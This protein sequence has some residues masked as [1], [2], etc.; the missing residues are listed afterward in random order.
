MVGRDYSK[1]GRILRRIIL[2]GTFAE[3]KSIEIWWGPRGTDFKHIK[4]VEEWVKK[5]LLA[6]EKEMSTKDNRQK[7]Y[8]SCKSNV[9]KWTGKRISGNSAKPKEQH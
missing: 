6:R 8:Y 2:L 3:L 1:I 7:W 4:L 9:Q 5:Y